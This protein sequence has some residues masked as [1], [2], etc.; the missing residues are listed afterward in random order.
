MGELRW[1]CG[2]SPEQFAELVARVGPRWEAQRLEVL[3]GRERK[4]AVG[5]GRRYDLV[6]GARLFVTLLHLRH[7]V[8]FRGLGALV[9]MSKDTAHR[10][11]VELVPL[12]AEVGFTAADGE[13]IT[14]MQELREFFERRGP[15]GG[16][17]LD[18]TFV[19][20]PRP[21]GGWDAQK[22]QFSGHRHR[23]CRS[24]QVL[25]DLDGNVIWVGDAEDGP[26]HDITGARRTGIAEAAA[27]TGTTIVA[28][29]GYRGWGNKPADPDG[30]DVLVPRS[31]G[32]RGA[33]TYNTEHARLRVRSEH[34]IRSLK[35]FTV[36]HHYRRHADTLTGA[37]RAIGAITTLQP[38]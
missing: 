25:T 30:L 16:V 10:A 29:R 31:G 23:H 5:A 4:R 15:G 11:V 37:L 18:G 33:G 19:P 17:L 14:S 7:N 32:P 22:S 21:G 6:F 8:P 26:T 24:T 38:A 13:A 34:G 2:V 12:L 35:R 36:L 27:A 3:S 28:D 1:L 20:T 9:G